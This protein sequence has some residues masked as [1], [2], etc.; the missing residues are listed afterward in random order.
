MAKTWGQ[1]YKPINYIS[2]SYLQLLSNR[3]IRPNYSPNGIMAYPGFMISDNFGL[4]LQTGLFRTGSDFELNN[5]TAAY[6]VYRFS[7]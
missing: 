4:E 2:V 7:V 3:P 5:F 6:N 1:E